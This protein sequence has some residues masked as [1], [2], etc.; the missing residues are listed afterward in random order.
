MILHSLRNPELRIRTYSI[1]A[2]WIVFTIFV[3]K[4]LIFVPHSTDLYPEFRSVFRYCVPTMTNK[5]SQTGH[6][7]ACYTVIRSLIRATFDWQFIFELEDKT[8]R[9][10]EARSWSDSREKAERMGWKDHRPRSH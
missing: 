10:E 4:F 2:S 5:R 9:R 1:F 8:Q 7:Y 6:L 3:L